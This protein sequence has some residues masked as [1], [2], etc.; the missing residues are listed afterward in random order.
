MSCLVWNSRGLGN[1]GAFQDLRQLIAIIDPKLLFLSEVMLLAAQCSNWI[2]VF[3]FNG[4]FSVDCVRHS[5]GLLLFWKEPF[6]VNILSF[7]EGH[8][9]C[10]VKNDGEK[11][12]VYRFL[13]QSSNSHS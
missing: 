9:D 8:I 6:D 1:P 12:E 2:S 4:S 13:R 3:Q 11:M 10:I 5:G 7:S